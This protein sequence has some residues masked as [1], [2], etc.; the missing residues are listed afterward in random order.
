MR[1][2]QPYEQV[3]KH[4]RARDDIWIASQGEYIA[5]WQ[6]RDNAALKITVSEEKC[7][8]HT[9]LE[10]AVIEKFP[11][12]FLDSPIAP[13]PGTTFSGEV[14]ITLDSAL[15]KKETLIEILKRE[16]ILNYRIANEGEFMLSQQKVGDLLEEIDARM[17]QRKGR[18]TEAD[19]GAVRQIVLDKLAAHRLPLLRVWY[20]PRLNGVAVRAVFS[21]RYDV[22]RAITN[23]AH[24]RAL[25]Q[26]YDAPSTLYLRAFCPFYTARQVKE[27]AAKPWCS[28]IALH[29]EFVTNARQYGDEFK[30]AE[31]EKTHLEKLTGRPILGVGMH[32]GELTRNR[33]KHTEDVIQQVGFLYDTTPRPR[34]YFFPFRQVLNGHL[35]TVYGLA[36]VLSDV[37]VPP[38]RSYEQVFYERAMAKLTEIYEQNGI[39][40]LMLHPVYFGFLT[41]LSRPRN[42]I[43]LAKFFLR[44]FGHSSFAYFRGTFRNCLT[45][46]SC[47]FEQSGTI[48]RPASLG[49]VMP[50]GRRSGW[51]P[52]LK[53]IWAV[54]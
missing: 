31:A 3:L 22:D 6:Q 49:I 50:S 12:E 41:Y 4:I 21:P 17:R 20:H 37:N 14:W 25:E 29:G 26:R 34:R 19:I 15:E 13:C 5:W 44:Y 42:W 8:V 38:G 45:T 27:L 9:S 32:G 16:G 10:N 54:S 43:P 24:V 53:Q 52:L 35:S 11:G 1:N 51:Q 47:S 48:C 23:L 18:L 39:F 46:T 36:H 30:A 2:Y 7:Q 33:S 28:E 40:V